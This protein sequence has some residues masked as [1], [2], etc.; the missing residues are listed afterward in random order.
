MARCPFYA[1]AGWNFRPVAEECS[2]FSGRST[3][4]NWF[5]S[6]KLGLISNEDSTNL[7]LPGGRKMTTNPQAGVKRCAK[8]H[9]GYRIPATAAFMR[10][11]HREGGSFFARSA[12]RVIEMPAPRPTVLT[13]DCAPVIVL[14]V[15][16][17]VTGCRLTDFIKL[18]L[19]ANLWRSTLES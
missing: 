7:R 10:K 8:A 6:V 13:T 2:D 16:R 14:P 12:H 3:P 4:D 5:P 19:G 15:H 11:R 18:G 1:S 9:S 17:S